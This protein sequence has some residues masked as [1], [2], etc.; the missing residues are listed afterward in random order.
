MKL[1]VFKDYL[2]NQELFKLAAN[3]LKKISAENIKKDSRSTFAYITNFSNEKDIFVKVYRRTDNKYRLRYLCRKS[4]AFKVFDLAFQLLNSNIN[5]PLPLLAMEKRCC[6]ILKLSAIIHQKVTNLL[7]LTELLS[8]NNRTKKFLSQTAEL[9]AKLHYH[10]I[11]H[12]DTKISN[13]YCCGT[14]E[15]F[16]T[17]IWDL[18]GCKTFNRQLTKR[19]RAIDICR[20]MASLADFII[21]ENLQYNITLFYT[22]FIKLY[23][24]HSGIVLSIDELEQNITK[25]RKESR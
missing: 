6:R 9:F 24:Q 2:D 1:K 7:E 21:R 25:N 5:T 3:P 18:D 19:E 16:Q 11:L 13:L 12:N 4:R 15:D 14:V 10:G 23:Q 8:N 22:D 20:F 17:G